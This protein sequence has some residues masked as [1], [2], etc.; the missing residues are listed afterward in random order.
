MMT[1]RRIDDSRDRP[2]A[3]E[4][5]GDLAD[6]RDF[7]GF[8]G[9]AVDDTGSGPLAALELQALSPLAAAWGNAADSRRLFQLFDRASRRQR[10]QP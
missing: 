7:D 8:R 3:I 2:I 9:L 4:I 6:L 10:G 5:I 1:L